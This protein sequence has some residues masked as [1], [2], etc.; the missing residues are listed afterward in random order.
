MAMAMGLII[1]GMVVATPSRIDS[2]LRGTADVIDVVTL[3]IG[4]RQVRLL[5]VAP[6][7]PALQCHGP[8]RAGTPCIIHTLAFL[9]KL[10]GRLALNCQ[11]PHRATDAQG[12]LICFLPRTVA[13]HS[14][15]SEAVRAGMLRSDSDV[16]RHEEVEARSECRGIWAGL[17]E[18]CAVAASS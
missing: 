3:E 2:G 14:V 4:G 12:E 1:L 13:L 10:T 15:N 5:G 8:T 18:A 17:E 6:P 9:R 11:P 7:D 16:F